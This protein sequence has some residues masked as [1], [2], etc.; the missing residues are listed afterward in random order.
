MSTY[1]VADLHGMYNLYEA[2]NKFLKPEDT[3]YFLG[4]AIDRGPDSWKLMKAILNNPQWIYIQGNHERMFA[5]AIYEYCEEIGGSDYF[6]DHALN[7]GAETFESWLKEGAYQ[8]W[9]NILKSLPFYELYI[10][11][12]G[13]KIYLSHAGFTPKFG[14]N[15]EVIIP[16]YTSLLTNRN[17]FND[18][19]DEE[20][21][22]DTTIVHG[23]TPI[24]YLI[25]SN[26]EDVNKWDDPGVY[27]YCDG[28]KI[29]IDCG[30][31]W[32]KA[33]VLLDLDTFD[34]Y[35]FKL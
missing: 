32:I 34:E 17:H 28:H 9:G 18:T 26:Q 24:P 30:A 12:H 21:F 25:Y 13:E 15:G 1:C 29:N 22:F 4:D 2:I 23:H 6:Y 20:N 27:Y 11:E 7:G 14:D 31:C 19:W 16:H 10:N 3:V 5:D 8:E 33:T 35:I